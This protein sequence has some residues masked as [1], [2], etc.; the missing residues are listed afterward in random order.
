MNICNAITAC[1]LALLSTTLY[2]SQLTPEQQAAKIRGFALYNQFKDGEKDLRI[3]AT[4]GD[5]ESQFYLAKDLQNTARHMTAESKKWYAAAA[6]QGDLYAMFQLYAS[7]SD[8]CHAM[9]NCPPD[10]RTSQDWKNLIIKTAEPLASQG[11]GEA[12]YILFLTTKKLDWLE[13]SAD[14]GFPFG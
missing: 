9:H 6:E 12:M 4:A 2:A 3:A 10:T 13:R 7:D 11:D 5:R 8:L 14:A 1:V